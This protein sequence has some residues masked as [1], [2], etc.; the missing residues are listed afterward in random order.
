MTSLPGTSPAEPR[1]AAVS[2]PG[3]LRARWRW[4]GSGQAAAVFALSEAGAALCAT[5]LPEDSGPPTLRRS[6]RFLYLRLRRH[7]YAPAEIAAWADRLVPFL[8][9]GNDAFVFFRHDEVGRGAELALELRRAVTDA[10]TSAPGPSRS[11][12]S[13]RPAR[14]RPG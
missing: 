4:G 14:R 9:A 2:Y 3:G 8:S 10:S 11:R 13:P 6:G 1:N 12:A 7:D 5:E